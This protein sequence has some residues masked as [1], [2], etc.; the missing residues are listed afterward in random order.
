MNFITIVGYLSGLYFIQPDLD[1]VSLLRTAALVHAI[2]ALLCRLI[3]A[4]SSR[5]KKIWT[6][7]GLLLGFWALAIL[8]LLP[9]KQKNQRRGKEQP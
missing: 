3:A 6:V 7:A 4:Q 1:S 8:F 9:S 2:D 5:D